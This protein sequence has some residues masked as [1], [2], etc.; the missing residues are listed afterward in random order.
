V[1]TGEWLPA[2][3]RRNGDEEWQ[4]LVLGAGVE[5]GMRELGRKGELVR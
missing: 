1:L 5:E 2:E 4:R 3:R